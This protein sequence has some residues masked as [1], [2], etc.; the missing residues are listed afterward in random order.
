MDLEFEN[1]IPSF[2][3][4]LAD[5]DVKNAF[6]LEKNNPAVVGMHEF[7]ACKHLAFCTGMTFGD[8]YSPM[9]FDPLAQMD[10]DE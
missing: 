6:R 9:N 5:N 7:V 4:L 8:L 3:H 1:I 10:V 2:S